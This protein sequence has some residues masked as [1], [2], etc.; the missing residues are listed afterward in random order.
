MKWLR[1]LFK[2]IYST[3]EIE[4]R[5]KKFLKKTPHS[6]ASVIVMLKSFPNWYKEG[7]MRDMAIETL[8]LLW[9]QYY[10]DLYVVQEYMSCSRMVLAYRKAITTY[11]HR[12]LA[13]K[14]E[15][16]KGCE[17]DKTIL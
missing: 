14:R 8:I 5:L 13:A 4:K 10:K 11:V 2:K 12:V 9:N 16:E 7:I 1:N 17:T 6:E 15:A 3:R